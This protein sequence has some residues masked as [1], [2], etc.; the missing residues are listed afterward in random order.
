[1][2]TIIFLCGFCRSGKDYF[3]DKLISKQ[4]LE[5]YNLYNFPIDLDFS[6]CLRVSF[7]HQ[8]KVLFCEKN[9]I[10]LDYLEENKE[11]YRYKLIEF[12][13][14]IRKYNDAYFAQHILEKIRESDKNL[15][16]ITDLRFKVEYETIVKIYKNVKVFQVERIGQLP[17]NESD[18]SFINE[19]NF[20]VQKITYS[21]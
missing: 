3:A 10:D 16:L 6:N 21:L 4:S 20:P 5:E 8:L 14:E 19:I 15:I 17:N 12:A 9:N 18:F 2:K 7:A 1:M 13:K 11:R